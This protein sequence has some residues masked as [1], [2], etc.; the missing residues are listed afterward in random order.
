M[1]RLEDGHAKKQ[2]HTSKKGGQ[3]Q[4]KRGWNSHI[5]LV[6]NRIPAYSAVADPTCPLRFRKQKLK[7]GQLGKDAQ[8]AEDRLIDHLLKESKA[9][10]PSAAGKARSPK[11]V[12]SRSKSR[13]SLGASVSSR[14]KTSGSLGLSEENLLSRTQKSERKRHRHG[15]SQS[16]DAESNITFQDGVHDFDVVRHIIFREDCLSKLKVLSKE[17][18]TMYPLVN[19]VTVKL[20]QKMIE[21]I[22]AA[23][24]AALMIV[25]AIWHWR[26]QRVVSLLE[27]RRLPA[28]G[29]DL[30]PY[31]FIFDGDNY[32]LKMTTDLKFLEENLALKEWLGASFARNPFCLKKEDVLDAVGGMSVMET[33]KSV[34]AS[35]RMEPLAEGARYIDRLRWAS[36]VIL[37]EES[38]CGPF[39]EAPSTEMTRGADETANH[40]HAKPPAAAKAP[41]VS[42]K[43][44]RPATAGPRLSKNGGKRSALMTALVRNNA[45]RDELTALQDELDALRALKK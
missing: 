2:K 25:E 17:S 23:R 5:P 39:E 6:D 4:R 38:I 43:Q 15:R 32:L 11:V 33:G 41:V 26:N 42:A 24:T 7:R 18:K 37:A 19:H 34:E 21:N 27:R 40:G 3:E 10:S 29:V 8:K 13:V 35:A 44:T 12:A 28:P 20:L 9:Y 14:P 1:P 36:L 45:L 31:P 30:S 16:H 22:E